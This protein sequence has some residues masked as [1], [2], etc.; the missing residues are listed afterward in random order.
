MSVFDRVCSETVR[1]NQFEAN[2]SESVCGSKCHR[3]EHGLEA[4]GDSRKAMQMAASRMPRERGTFGRG[5]AS[6]FDITWTTC[7]VEN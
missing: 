3:I 5:F 7:S 2:T 4:L 1:T 6:M